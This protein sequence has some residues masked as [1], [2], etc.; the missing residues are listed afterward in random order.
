MPRAILS[1]TKAQKAVHGKL[2]QK[3]RTRK[4]SRMTC[5]SS[6]GLRMRKSWPWAS[7]RTA[8]R[9]RPWP[10]RPGR[11]VPPRCI[12]LHPVQLAVV[13]RGL[14]E[15][16]ALGAHE[17][18]ELSKRGGGVGVVLPVVFEGGTVRGRFLLEL[19]GAL[20]GDITEL[21]GLLARPVCLI[22]EGKPLG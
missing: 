17:L 16:P 15:D 6:R 12:G 1:M 11:A 7:P 10:E 20:E 8:A 2:D 19:L 5:S 13:V 21:V 14:L 4:T 9:A 18:F 3:C 22:V